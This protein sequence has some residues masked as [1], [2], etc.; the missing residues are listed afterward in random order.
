MTDYVVTATAT[1]IET[2]VGPGRA[3][4][5]FLRGQAVPDDITAQ[6]RDDLLRAGDIAA[7]ATGLLEEAEPDGPGVDLDGD[8]VPEGNA[9]QVVD[10]VNEDGADRIARAQLALDAENAK[11]DTARKGLTADLQK[12]LEA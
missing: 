5:D 12:I 2:N 11:G 4:I 3:R 9:H 10:W 8:G 1:T 7:V 6:D